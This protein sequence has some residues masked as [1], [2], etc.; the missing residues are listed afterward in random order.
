MRRLDLLIQV[1]SRYR[2]DAKFRARLLAFPSWATIPIV[3]AAMIGMVFSHIKK[4]QSS[5]SSI[6]I[7]MCRTR[8]PVAL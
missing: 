7:G 8:M 1:E 5:R 4:L 3:A 6:M 2:F